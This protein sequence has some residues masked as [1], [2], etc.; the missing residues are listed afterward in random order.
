MCAAGGL[1]PQMGKFWVRFS[2]PFGGKIGFFN[3]E[4]FGFYP[5]IFLPKPTK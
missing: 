5:L 4:K 3:G 2:M 1:R